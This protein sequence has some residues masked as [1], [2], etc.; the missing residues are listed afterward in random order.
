MHRDLVMVFSL[1]SYIHFCVFV[2]RFL[3][4]TF[5]SNTN[6]FHF[7]NNFF[8]LMIMLHGMQMRHMD[9]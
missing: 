8:F 5:I 1:R 9:K 2:E 7:I 6:H 4:L 3:F